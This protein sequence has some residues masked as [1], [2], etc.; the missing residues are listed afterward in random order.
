MA[1]RFDFANRQF[2]LNVLKDHVCTE[3]RVFYYSMQVRG[4][5]MC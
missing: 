2:F 3:E 5:R 1:S 4:S